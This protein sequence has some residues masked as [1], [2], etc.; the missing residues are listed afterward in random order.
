MLDKKLLKMWKLQKNSTALQINA[1]SVHIKSHPSSSV[2]EI[3]RAVITRKI[4]HVSS[5]LIFVKD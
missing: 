4:V 5:S 3:R 1:N 2:F